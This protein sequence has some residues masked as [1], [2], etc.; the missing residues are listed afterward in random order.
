VDAAQCSFLD[1]HEL[2]VVISFGVDDIP[3]FVLYIFG[4]LWDGLVFFYW[5]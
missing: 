3:Y 1:G 2:M 4:L 5:M